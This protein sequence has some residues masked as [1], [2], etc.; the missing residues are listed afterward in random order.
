MC[1]TF[2]MSLNVKLLVCSSKMQLVRQKINLSS[3]FLSLS[4]GLIALVCFRMYFCFFHLPTVLWLSPMALAIAA[5]LVFFAFSSSLNFVSS[6]GISFPVFL[7]F[8]LLLTFI[9]SWFFYCWSFICPHILPIVFLF[10]T[11]F[12]VMSLM[13]PFADSLLLFTDDKS[14]C[15]IWFLVKLSSSFVFTMVVLQFWL[16]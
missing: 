7:P 9:G 1:T 8:F 16:M 12:F 6:K 10:T 13:T 5:W 3:L 15:I 4:N 14:S 11:Y 2:D